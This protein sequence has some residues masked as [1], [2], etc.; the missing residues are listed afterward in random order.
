[1]PRV[2]TSIKVLSIIGIV[3][4]ALGFC[5]SVW[6]VFNTFVPIGPPNPA[7]ED[8]NHQ[9]PYILYIIAGAVVSLLFNLL[10]LASSIGSLRL[11]RWARYGM[12]AY[13]ILAL[14]ELFTNGIINL[15][16]VLPQTEHAFDQGNPQMATTFKLFTI[17]AFVI[18]L[19]LALVWL[20][21]V[22]IFFNRKIARDAFNGVFP[23][24]PPPAPPIF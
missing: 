6:S 1:M 15:I 20:L 4:S 19:L 8:L 14:L 2:P 23:P 7:L 13:A 17:G 11:Y 22:F 18:A 21:L 12:M 3:L 5:G 24:E 9:T 10:L 16:F